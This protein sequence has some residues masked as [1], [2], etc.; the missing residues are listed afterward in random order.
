MCV[1][2]VLSMHAVNESVAQVVLCFGFVCYFLGREKKK[3]ADKHTQRQRQNTRFSTPFGS[4]YKKELG[5]MY[6]TVHSHR[7]S[8]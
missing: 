1:R 2:V 3:L 5:I 7:L 8:V 6:N 4:I